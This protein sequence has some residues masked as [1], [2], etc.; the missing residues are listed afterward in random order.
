MNRKSTRRYLLLSLLC[1]IAALMLNQAGNG[2]ATILLIFVS[3]ALSTRACSF[4]NPVQMMWMSAHYTFCLM[5]SAILY[6]SN[7]SSSFSAAIYLSVF[8]TVF[9]GLT[10]FVGSKKVNMT[11][12]S[13][14][15]NSYF[16]FISGSI[17]LLYA[18][19]GGSFLYATPLMG[20]LLAAHCRSASKFSSAAS[21]GIFAAYILIYA[22]FYWSE[23]GRLVLAGSLLAP[24][25]AVLNRYN[26]RIAKIPLLVLT[27]TGGLFGSLLRIEGATPSTIVMAA[28][29]DSAVSPLVT[30]Q[31]F[32]NRLDQNAPIRWREWWDQVTLYF[33][34][35][36]PRQW[37]PSKPYGFGF[38]YVID[39]LESAYVL[40]GHSIAATF[41]GEHI[42]YLNSTLFFFAT[43]FAMILVIGAVRVT[44]SLGLFLGSGSYLVAVYIPTFYWGGMASFSQRFIFGFCTALG[45]MLALYMW[46][47]ISGKIFLRRP[48]VGHR[49]LQ[50]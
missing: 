45:V 17:I 7:V 24:L 11:R 33:L 39:N 48:P 15:L 5:P 44:Q 10:F 41:M 1:C 37:W 14:T 29:R 9:I 16:M 42:Y 27:G 23:F 28:L 4:E 34:G 46:S 21:Y 49:S 8:T 38:Q 18:T 3:A 6:I 31:D 32:L 40:S 19:N 30:A 12:P 47:R 43:I 20:M 36:F 25:L 13:V 35:P 22:I 50:Q 2:T 26:L